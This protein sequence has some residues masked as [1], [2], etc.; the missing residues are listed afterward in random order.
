MRAFALVAVSL[1]FAFSRPSLAADG[2]WWDMTLSWLGYST[3]I[4]A[5]SPGTAAA[6]M[7]AVPVA[8]PA[9]E[10]APPPR[11][12]IE[13]APPPTP[14]TAGRV[15]CQL[16]Y[17]PGEAFSVETS[18]F[19]V[20]DFQSLIL[21]ELAYLKKKYP[22]ADRATLAAML[23][24]ADYWR[25]R[26]QELYDEATKRREELARRYLAAIEKLRQA[27]DALP[28]GEDLD[29]SL[30][31]KL[32][33]GQPPANEDIYYWV[34]NQISASGG[35]DNG[36]SAPPS[37]FLYAPGSLCHPQV[38]EF[39]FDFF[40]IPAVKN[41]IADFEAYLAGLK[42]EL[43]DLEKRRDELIKDTTLTSEQFRVA[44]ESLIEER[45]ALQAKIDGK[46][47][48]LAGIKQD[49]FAF[50]AHYPELRNDPGILAFQGSYLEVFAISAEI[51]ALMDEAR[52]LANA[53]SNLNTVPFQPYD[54]LADAIEL[55]L[56]LVFQI[57]GADDTIAFGI[58]DAVT[59]GTGLVVF[60]DPTLE[61]KPHA[62]LVAH[63][64][65]GN[66]LTSFNGYEE[67][68]EKLKTLFLVCRKR[69]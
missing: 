63:F 5:P 27:L 7:V 13:V 47:V 18:S 2:S 26:G 22:N 11:P 42:A 14:L 20:S 65:G 32:I 10:I 62:Q 24:S 52:S 8:A 3:S 6:T 12:V 57:A 43:A 4:P 30:R 48:E 54:R 50:L 58:G 46:E 56:P 40:A 31:E 38:Q 28:C 25:Q 39:V 67:G 41:A 66:V 17:E 35:P 23:S 49:P 16:Q 45:F 9:P 15:S 51:Q 60:H 68:A 44:I 55:G 53:L 61:G 69:Y 37:A 64:S 59:P 1:A 34:S 36:F 33:A 21:S 29:P 19:L